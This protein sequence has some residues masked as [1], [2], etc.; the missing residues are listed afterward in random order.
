MSPAL[1]RC[2]QGERLCCRLREYGMSAQVIDPGPNWAVEWLFRLT[3]GFARLPWALGTFLRLIGSKRS[4]GAAEISDG[5]IQSV[6]MF[7]YI[8]GDSESFTFENRTVY[9]VPDPRV[10]MESR[11]ITLYTT[12]I[13][14]FP[15]FGRVV[16][17]K[18]SG[19]DHTLGLLARL[20]ADTALKQPIM[21]NKDVRIILDTDCLG[22]QVFTRTKNLPTKILWDCYQGIARHLLETPIS[23]YP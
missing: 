3:G 20:N 12:R 14:R 13:R 4:L 11:G 22:W 10:T 5:Q 16:D 9:W 19:D 1:N 21:S 23:P 18:W 17:V 8:A 2:R 7:E 15:V 6:R